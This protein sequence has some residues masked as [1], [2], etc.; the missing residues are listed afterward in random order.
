MDWLVDWSW[1]GDTCRTLVG[2][3]SFY[4]VGPGIKLGSSG[5][6]TSSFIYGG[7]T[8]APCFV[9]GSQQGKTKNES[10]MTPHQLYQQRQQLGWRNCLEVALHLQGQ[11]PSPVQG[12]LEENGGAGHPSQMCPPDRSFHSWLTIV[13]LCEI[14]CKF[15]FALENYP[16][17]ARHSSSCWEHLNSYWMKKKWIDNFQLAM[18]Y[19]AL[20]CPHCMPH[21]SL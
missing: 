21:S 5:L 12:T 11:Q 9:S 20:M 16:R 19:W 1:V 10:W 13:I 8:P 15:V 3:T 17:N 7:I 4:H 6:A 18:G 2:V 14:C